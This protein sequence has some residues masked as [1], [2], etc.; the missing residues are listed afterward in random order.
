MLSY[1]PPI[2]LLCG[3]RCE[4]SVR[5]RKQS[6]SSAGTN[7]KA[8]RRYH[9]E[10]H[11]VLSIC[12]PR[13]FVLLAAQTIKMTRHTSFVGVL[14]DTKNSQI[15]PHPKPLPL[16]LALNIAVPHHRSEPQADHR[17]EGGVTVKNSRHP[18]VLVSSGG[19]QEKRPED[20]TCRNMP[21]YDIEICQNLPPNFRGKGM[22]KDLAK[23]EITKG[24]TKIFYN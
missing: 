17:K 24:K 3:R 6:K 18:F 20:E 1:A 15:I 5:A 8:L 10:G 21:I 4:R 9:S 2:L 12:R 7:Q 11:P 14:S 23:I 19:F 13:F 16:P 22:G